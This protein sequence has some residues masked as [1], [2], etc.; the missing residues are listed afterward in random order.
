MICNTC[1]TINNCNTCYRCKNC[2]TFNMCHV[3]KDSIFYGMVTSVS[4]FF[5]LF[6]IFEM[7]T[8]ISNV[9]KI[10]E[11][12]QNDPY[13]LSVKSWAII[14]SIFSFFSF[15][16]YLIILLFTYDVSRIL[17]YHY[18]LISFSM[19]ESL[20]IIVKSLSI[21]KFIF[22]ITF[23]FHLIWTL[24][25]CDMYYHC[26]DIIPKKI[27]DMIH[28]STIFY[29]IQ[30][31]VMIVIIVYYCKA[32]TDSAKHIPLWYKTSSYITKS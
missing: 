23:A 12:C 15:S 24:I 9:G 19:I 28:M 10:K 21:N 7:L 30:L 27:N 16:Y 31:F 8:L 20:K 11:N 2:Y 17:T 4:I 3:C 13:N 5:Y 22:L 25:G 14:A 29:I 26:F 18:T 32:C 6:K 1:H